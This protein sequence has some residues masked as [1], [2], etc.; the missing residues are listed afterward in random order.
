MGVVE[1]LADQ[2]AQD[3]LEAAA[4]LDDDT[5][6]A[7]IGDVLGASSATTHEAYS[8]AIRV[9]LAERRAREFLQDALKKAPPSAP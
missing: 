1:D 3:A 7:K 8:T 5:I 6:L 4:K 9:R 2:L